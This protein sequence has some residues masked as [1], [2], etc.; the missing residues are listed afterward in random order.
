MIDRLVADIA[1]AAR[2]IGPFVRETPLV[3]SEALS[4]ELG[5]EV[6]LKLENLQITGSFKLR[7]AT[8]KLLSLPAAVRVRGVVAASS[9]NHGAAVAH[10]GRALGVPVTVFVPE[11]ASPAKVS[12]MRRSGAE[13]HHV[14]TDGLDTELHA[15]AYASDRAQA[16]ISPYN[17]LDVVAGQGSVAVE[18]RRQTDAIDVV[19]VATGG[20]GLISGIAADLKAHWPS[21]RVVGAVP[22]NSPVMAASIRAGHVIEMPS[23]PTLSD[24]TAGGIEQ[25]SVTFEL[26]RTLVDDWIEIPEDEI[27][28]AMRHCLE[29]EHLLVEGSAAVAVGALQR[30]SVKPATR[31]AVV[32]CGANIS[33]E[34]LKSIL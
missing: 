9:G 15:R 19:V 8:N 6:L 17:D 5:S 25:D 24:G 11:G 7:G 34:R 22:L 20:G 1:T 28:R 31:A 2:R 10:A 27:A 4:A 33:A 13:V 30:M 12:A 26:C 16:Y 14:G 23:L 29:T 21:V 18:M 3:R 32:L